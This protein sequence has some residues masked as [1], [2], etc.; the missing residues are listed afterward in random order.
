MN[1]RS[2]RLLGRLGAMAL[3]AALAI[4]LAGVARGAD[5]TFVLNNAGR[6]GAPGGT[7]TGNY[8]QTFAGVEIRATP[9][10]ATGKYN[11]E[12]VDFKI[13]LSWDWEMRRGRLSQAPDPS[14][15]TAHTTR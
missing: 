1:S 10:P 15:C 14:P 7:A 4:P 3:I 9:D 8:G 6:G 5:N 12:A 11:L 13:P 2:V